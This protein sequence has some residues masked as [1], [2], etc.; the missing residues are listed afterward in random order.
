MNNIAVYDV[1]KKMLGTK[2]EPYSPEAEVKIQDFSA[3]YGEQLVLEAARLASRE[4]AQQIS[5]TCV[6][7]AKERLRSIERR[8]WKKKLCGQS[9]GVLLG[10]GLSTLVPI[11]SNISQASTLTLTICVASS[12]IGTALLMYDSLT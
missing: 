12:L 10:V 2:G 4:G 7:K 9:G 8:N 11:S 3:D 1:V 6:D 5:T